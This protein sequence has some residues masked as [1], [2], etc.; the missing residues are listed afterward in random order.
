MLKIK[1]NNANGVFKTIEGAHIWDAFEKANL[2]MDEWFI[3][4]IEE[5][6]K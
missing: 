6:G 1:I 3:V 5:E 2:N 4:S